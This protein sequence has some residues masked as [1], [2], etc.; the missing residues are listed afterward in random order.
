MNGRAMNGRNRQSTRL[1]HVHGHRGARGHLP[2]NTLPGFLGA[3]EMGADILELDVVATA[4]GCLVVLHD[5]AL[6][7]ALARRDGAWITAPVPVFALTLADLR[8]FDVGRYNPDSAEAKRF[9]GQRPVDATPVPTLSE[10]LLLGRDRPGLRF[11]IEIKTSPL[12]PA[13]TPEPA[14]FVELLLADLQASGLPDRVIVQSFDWRILQ[15]LRAAAPDMKTGY[16]T[17]EQDWFDTVWRGLPRWLG[18]AR[19]PG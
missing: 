7:P 15:H 14:A 12:E 1:V 8:E 9:P 11:N 2:E 3:I 18:L 6:R 17:V 13:A 10:V 4:D 5:R 19:R 16:L